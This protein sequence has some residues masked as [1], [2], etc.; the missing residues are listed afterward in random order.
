MLSGKQQKRLLEVLDN[1]S[2]GPNYN[3]SLLQACIKNDEAVIKHHLK[4]KVCNDI[5]V[6]TN[7]DSSPL[8]HIVRHQNIGMLELILRK[9]C[10]VDLLHERCATALMLACQLGNVTMVNMLLKA[11]ANPNLGCGG[12]TTMVYAC[13]NGN[14]DIIRTILT[15][16][17]FVLTVSICLKIMCKDPTFST[18]VIPHRDWTIKTI[19]LH[20]MP[21]VVPLPLLSPELT[22]YGY[23]YNNPII[24]QYKQNPTLAIKQWK[25]ELA[26]VDYK[27]YLLIQQAG[28]SQHA[29]QKQVRFFNILLRLNHDTVQRIINVRH[30][31][32][33]EYI[34]II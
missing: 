28:M 11:G 15:H 34:V 13:V 3:I 4:S 22:L 10:D 24:T 9:K 14:K 7:G 21:S 27:T 19:L 17:N 12:N 23:E 20:T 30:G 18:Y 5:N 29:T 32:S 31:L 33:K 26:V 8:L 16:P 6:V 1:M 2:K 25:C